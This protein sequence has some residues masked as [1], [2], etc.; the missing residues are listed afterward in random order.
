[1]RDRRPRGEDDA[2]H[3]DVA[4]GLLVATTEILM[5][6]GDRYEVDGAP[7]VVE[8]T[9]VGAA[10]GSIMALARLTEATDAQPLAINPD[11]VVAPR[12]GQPD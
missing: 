10:R 2:R 12:P 3:A 8:A 11:H 7:D 1:M 6:T 9:I 5:V 4:Y